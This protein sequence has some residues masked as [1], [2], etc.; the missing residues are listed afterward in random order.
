MLIL[1]FMVSHEEQHYFTLAQDLKT[2]IANVRQLHPLGSMDVCR[3]FYGHSSSVLCRLST[4]RVVIP[5]TTILAWKVIATFLHK[6]NFYFQ[7]LSQSG[8]PN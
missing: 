8:L 4:K 1:I 6:I 7:T 2:W 5:K 3:K